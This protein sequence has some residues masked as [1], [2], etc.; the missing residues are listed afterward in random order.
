MCVNE[1]EEKIS[2]IL[3]SVFF[4]NLHLETSLTNH[5]SSG[6]RVV[7]LVRRPT[8]A[9]TFLLFVPFDI[10]GVDNIFINYNHLLN[11][12]KIVLFNS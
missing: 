8:L 12:N 3:L 5:S 6:L 9:L 10:N 11:T 2:F 4:S 7:T 1:K